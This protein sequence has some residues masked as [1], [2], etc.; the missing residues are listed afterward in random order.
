MHDESVTITAPIVQLLQY[1]TTITQDTVDRRQIK[2]EAAIEAETI[3]IRR[4]F[5]GNIADY[6]NTENDE[7]DGLIELIQMNKILENIKELLLK[8]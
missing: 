1:K 7:G 5:Q 4:M 2:K 6:E 8:A 3:S